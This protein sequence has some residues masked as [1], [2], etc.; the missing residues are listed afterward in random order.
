M[1]VWRRLCVGG[2]MDF[3]RKLYFLIMAKGND[4][5]RST[6]EKYVTNRVTGVFVIAKTLKLRPA[7]KQGFDFTNNTVV[8]NHCHQST[9][10]KFRSVPQ[11]GRMRL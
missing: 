7:C 9:F 4:G 8:W 11:N 2:G 6:S 10:L 3:Q 1:C 5:K